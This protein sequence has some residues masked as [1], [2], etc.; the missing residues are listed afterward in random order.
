MRR[1]C[2]TGAEKLV[3]QP[4]RR[5]G[6]PFRI[7]STWPALD[8]GP[9]GAKTKH[10]EMGTRGRHNQRLQPTTAAASMSRRG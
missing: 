4:L 2:V 8:R 7:P 6:P 9:R 5:S 10:G 1:V 3:V